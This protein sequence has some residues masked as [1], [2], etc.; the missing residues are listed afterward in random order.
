MG[1]GECLTVNVEREPYKSASS[2]THYTD[3]ALGPE[4]EGCPGE[5]LG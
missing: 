3:K 1:L 4:A 5:R 2:T